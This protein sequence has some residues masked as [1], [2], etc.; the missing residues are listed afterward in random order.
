MDAKAVNELLEASLTPVRAQRARAEG[1]LREME[2][3]PHFYGHLLESAVP[4]SPPYTA[5]G[6]GIAPVILCLHLYG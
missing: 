5:G 6:A 2:A 1:I 3:S 4:L